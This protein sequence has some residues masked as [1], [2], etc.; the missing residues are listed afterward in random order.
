HYSIVGAKLLRPNSEYH[1]AVTNQDVS[2]PIRFSLAITDASNVIEK[3]EITLNTG[4]TRLVPFAIGD[5]PES[6]YKLVAEG[7][8]GL[9]FKNETDL[10]YQ[11][12]SFSVF[13]QTDKSIYKPGD[14]VRFRV[15]VLDPN[16][17]PLP[18]ADSISVHINDAKANRIKQWKEGKL[19]KGVFESELTLST[20]PV[21]GAWTINVNVL[22]T[23]RGAG[24]F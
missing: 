15:L 24:I 9:T 10:E 2:E 17:K 7:L 8:S 3:Q 23:V 14:T 16:T 6:S 5:I 4:E 1:V 12:K 13:V 21:L 19:V 18:K 11:Q 22:G 20:A